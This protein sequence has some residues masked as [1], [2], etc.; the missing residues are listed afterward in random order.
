MEKAKDLL[1]SELC[2]TP[3]LLWALVLILVFL[4]VY[5]VPIRIIRRSKKGE[6]IIETKPL[7][8]KRK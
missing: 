3:V 2:K 6:T 1:F 8:T 5:K 7:R 4:I